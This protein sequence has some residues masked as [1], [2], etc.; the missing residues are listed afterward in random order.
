MAR[1]LSLRMLRGIG[2]SLV[3]LCSQF[4]SLAADEP[5]AAGDQAPDIWVTSIAS[6]RPVAD[7]SHSCVHFGAL[8]NGLLL[9]PADVVT[10]AD[11]DFASRTTLMTHP[12]AVWIVRVCDDGKHVASVDYRGNLQTFDTES[13]QATMHTAAFE[14]WAQTMEFVPGEETIIA[15]NE[16]GKLF[17]WKDGKV[18]KSIEIDKSS[19]TDV[20]FNK[21][22]DKLAIAD[23]AGN[24]HWFSW[25]ALES[26]GKTKVSEEACWCVQF[27]GDSP[28]VLVGTGDRKLYRCEA[29]SDQPPQAV[30]EGKD[31]LTRIAVSASGLIAVSELNGTVHVLNSEGAKL[32]APVS[33]TPSGIWALEWDGSDKLLVG[34]RRHGVVELTQGWALAT[35]VA[36][37]KAEATPAEPP[38]TE[39][40]QGEAPKTE[41]TP[42]EASATAPQEAADKPQ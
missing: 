41:A 5:A 26:V 33:T 21:A 12:A 15:G 6:Q 3:V 4:Q 38:Q 36:E 13:K 23:G 29:G 32:D 14:R 25:P 40:P 24:V 34:T 16:A 37:P 22:K 9:R 8:A 42:T 31:W 35:P 17:V 39:K 10:W 2:C 28:A 7:Q 19:L 1:L 20:A 11:D 18:E 30:L 27:I